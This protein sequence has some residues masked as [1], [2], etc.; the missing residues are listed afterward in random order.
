[1]QC[2]SPSWQIR[3][4]CEIFFALINLQKYVLPVAAIKHVKCLFLPI[5]LRLGVGILKTEART[6]FRPRFP[7]PIE[8][9][10]FRTC[11]TL[12]YSDMCSPILLVE[13]LRNPWVLVQSIW[14]GME[15]RNEKECQNFTSRVF[16]RILRALR[17]YEV[18]PHFIILWLQNLGQYLSH[19][20]SYKISYAWTEFW[21]VSRPKKQ[22]FC[23]CWATSVK[24]CLDKC[25]WKGRRE[26]NC[27]LHVACMIL[28]RLKWKAYKVTA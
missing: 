9:I 8:Y 3:L 15:R 6:Q 22:F 12:W 10:F 1:M 7:K 4:M 21:G 24:L 23:T 19:P 27:D 20:F 2:E 18:L 5:L 13:P 25:Q 16:D 17:N 14:V 28:L 26:K 11:I